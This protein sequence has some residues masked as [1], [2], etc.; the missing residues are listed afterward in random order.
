MLQS[1]RPND[2]VDGQ[3]RIELAPKESDT[4]HPNGS[5][6]INF[7]LD[8]FT[9]VV[10]RNPLERMYSHYLHWNRKNG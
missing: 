7:L 5:E 10:I 8:H 3:D 2:T 4:L 1:P 9:T 6:K